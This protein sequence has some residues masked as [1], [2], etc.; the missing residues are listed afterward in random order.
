MSR[1]A[2]KEK[3]KLSAMAKKYGVEHPMQNPLIKSQAMETLLKNNTV[4]TSRQQIEIY[5]ISTGFLFEPIN[6]QTF[7]NWGIR[8]SSLLEDI[9]TNQGIIDYR[10]KMDSENKTP[11]VWSNIL[12]NKTS[13]K[14][15]SITYNKKQIPSDR[16]GFPF[17]CLSLNISTF[18]IYRC[19]YNLVF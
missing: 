15:Y 2:G 14:R 6:E 8:V 19:R 10:Y 11:T 16:K 13:K 18:I 4:A 5:N 1:S 9:K 17:F 7:T 12:A 3:I